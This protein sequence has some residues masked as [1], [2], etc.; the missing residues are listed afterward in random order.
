MS[1]GQVPE[2][3]RRQTRWRVLRLGYGEAVEA[4]S[5]PVS[6]VSVVGLTCILVL[7]GLPLVKSDF[8]DPSL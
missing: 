7:I 3:S 4:V 2:G 8:K 6:L 5:R 1:C